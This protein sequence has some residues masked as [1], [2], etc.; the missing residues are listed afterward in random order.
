MEMKENLLKTDKIP[1][2]LC[3]I[4]AQPGVCPLSKG[5]IEEY[6]NT[7][8]ERYQNKGDNEFP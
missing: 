8:N 5:S 4:R 1:G 6:G 3:G 2:R 7:K